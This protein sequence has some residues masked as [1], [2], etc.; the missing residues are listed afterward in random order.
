MEG[1]WK[2]RNALGA[3]IDGELPAGEAARVGRHVESC[4][5]CRGEADLFRRLDKPLREYEVPGISDGEWRASWEAVSAALESPA[6][7]PLP[8]LLREDPGDAAVRFVRR[9]I[10]IAAAA[11]LL[12]STF[13]WS[14]ATDRFETSGG[15]E[16]AALE[17]FDRALAFE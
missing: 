10:P 2:H 8:A 12:L 13:A 1:C 7:I 11:L 17:L 16:S 9:L 4:T 14:V 3:Y 5:T 6:P 15:G